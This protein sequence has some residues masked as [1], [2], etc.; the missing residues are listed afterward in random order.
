M[1]KLLTILLFSTLLCSAGELKTWSYETE[2][3]LKTDRMIFYA[4]KGQCWK[5]QSQTK[6]LRMGNPF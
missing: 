6:P 5:K 1:Y 3:D 4:A 2:R